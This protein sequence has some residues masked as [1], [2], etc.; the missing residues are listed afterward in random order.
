[1]QLSLS[2]I[3]TLNASFAEDVEAYA[4]AGFD[5][6]GLWEMKLPEDDNA[7]LA[8]IRSHGLA[9]SNCVPAVPSFLQLAIPGM[10]GPADPMERA[11]AICAS[12]RRLARYEPECVLCLSGPLGGLTVVEGRAIVVDG[13]RRAADA[14][15]EAGVR[16]GFEPIHPSQH[17]SAGFICSLADAVDLLD[18][19]GL[20]DVGILADTYNL[21]G[22]EPTALADV[23]DR[24]AGVHVADEL[25]EPVPGVRTLPEAD[26]R[27]A[28]L[29]EA[30]R[31]AGWDGPL[32]VEIFSTPD[33]FWALPPDEAA[34]RAY[35]S[36]TALA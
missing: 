12:V 4:A 20:A 16:L 32:D 27:S 30:L 9:V 19:A 10:E 13:L 14:A 17:D 36:L 1:M 3:S 31:R 23:I 25:P 6:I 22:E 2:T 21:A 8:L 18:E 33:G 11:D 35:A 5:A 34:R 28:A 15:H 7:N 26:G 29:V 24:I